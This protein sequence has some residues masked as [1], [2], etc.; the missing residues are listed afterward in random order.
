MF[1]SPDGDLLRLKVEGGWS[2]V[3]L[4]ERYAHVLPEGQ[5]AAIRAWW[6]L[7]DTNADVA[8]AMA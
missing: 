6:H 5:Q 7:A 2:T 3:A 8:Q 4:V 1:W